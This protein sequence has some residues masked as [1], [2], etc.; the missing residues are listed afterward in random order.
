MTFFSK[1]CGILS[2]TI[3]GLLALY[4]PGFGSLREHL[5]QTDL[6]GKDM[7]GT[8]SHHTDDLLEPT[9]APR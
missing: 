8:T 2:Q 4:S 9:C 1:G 5:H 6:P 3:S 7:G